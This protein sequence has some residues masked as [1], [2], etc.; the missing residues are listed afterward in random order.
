MSPP[1][2]V[3]RKWERVGRWPVDCANT[4]KVGG[5]HNLI[6]YEVTRGKLFYRRN[7]DSK[8]SNEISGARLGENGIIV[9]T[10]ELPAY[11]QTRGNGIA[12]DADGSVRS[13]Y[14]TTRT[15]IT[16]S[17]TVCSRPMATRLPRNTGAARGA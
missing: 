2:E 9:L 4:V 11:K 1:A 14:N 16:A 10:I 13:V 5:P 17:R 3:A 12:K 8:H 15:A 6:S 7:D